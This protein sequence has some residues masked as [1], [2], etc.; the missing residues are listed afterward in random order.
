MTSIKKNIFC[1]LFLSTF[2]LAHSQLVQVEY[3]QIFEN[4]SINL[5]KKYDFILTDSLSIYLEQDSKSSKKENNNAYNQKTYD[6]DFGDKENPNI[7]YSQKK[8][9]YFQETFFGESLKIKENELGNK[10]KIIDSTKNIAN[11]K[12]KLATKEFR[13]RKYFVWY[14]NDI[15]T[16]FGPWKF[17]GIGGLILEARDEKNE[18]KLIALQINSIDDKKSSKEKNLISKVHNLFNNEKK[19]L[20]ID[21]LRTFIEEKNQIIL[22]RIKQQ[23]P[24]GTA[25]PKLNSDCDECDDS[26]E[27][28]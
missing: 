25:S 9:L 1:L 14:T 17:K 5:N 26:L 2:F 12:C 16:T 22:N 19:I 15:P 7:Y 21:E 8:N 27:N 24:R 28:Y 3:Q 18:F 20:T 23:L 10:W 11:Y 6:L 4:S 13:G